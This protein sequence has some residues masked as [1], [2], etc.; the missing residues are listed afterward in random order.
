M[1]NILTVDVEEWFHP[2]A[3]QHLFPP[4]SWASQP[5]RVEPLVDL[6]LDL[7]AKHQARA[8]FFVLGWVAKA[9]PN[10]LKKIIRA[11]HEVASHSMNH[12]MLTKMSPEEVREDLSA[13]VKILEDISG[14]RIR[15]FRAPTFSIGEQNLW[16]FDILAEL[17]F[18]YDS[19]IYPIWH[20]RYGIPNAPRTPFSVETKNNSKIVEFPM[21]TVKIKNK[22]IPFGGGGYLR[23]LPLWFTQWGI[24][25]FNNEG[26]PAIIYMHP[27]E[28]DS[29]QPRVQLG[30][31]QSFRH[32]GR[33]RKN[34]TKLSNLLKR[35]DWIAMEDYFKE[36]SEIEK[37]PVKKLNI[38]QK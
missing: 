38:Q 8:T 36:F 11:G 22:N 21:P 23:L 10:L 24:K 34:Q 16:A 7:F 33:I 31:L 28:F 13:S 12:R 30:K 15:G 27:W 18:E 2:E 32:Y 1:K 6:L 5:S 26:N 4:E 9:N 20:D 19:S 37:I 25:K 35:F 3:L 29:E 14:Q 17:G